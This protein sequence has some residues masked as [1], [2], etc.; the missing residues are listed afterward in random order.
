VFAFGPIHFGSAFFIPGD[1]MTSSATLAENRTVLF[2]A[3]PALWP[4]W[5][6]LPV[7]RRS[8]GH[9]E[10]GV[11]FDSRSAGLTG[12]SATVFAAN[13]FALPASLNEFLALPHETFDT[14]EELAD[15][16]WL[17]D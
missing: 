11:I 8:K 3:T 6:F 12:Y 17:V 1:D 7:V 15:A 4:S 5:P 16:Q 14:A 13:L 9:E 2:V 10:L